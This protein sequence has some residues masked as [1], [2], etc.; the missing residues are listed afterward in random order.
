MS[1]RLTGC[2]SLSAESLQE[3]CLQRLCG[4]CAD[5]DAEAEI[6]AEKEGK[7]EEN[8]R[9]S[10]DRVDSAETS[11]GMGQHDTVADK[12]AELSGIFFPSCVAER[13]LDLLGAK[14]RLCDAFLLSL[15]NSHLSHLRSA[16]LRNCARIS[17]RGLKVLKGHRLCELSVHGLSAGAT[18]TDLI[19]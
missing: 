10:P 11:E 8:D 2:L 18:V 6:K 17:V 5:A 3:L 16:H 1:Q 9:E 14:R 13:L 4:L 15:F 7:T 12:S 19:R